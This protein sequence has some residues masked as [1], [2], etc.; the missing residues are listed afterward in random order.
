MDDISRACTTY[1]GVVTAN[2][3]AFGSDLEEKSVSDFDQKLPAPPAN[4]AAFGSDLEEKSV[5]DFDQPQ[6][7]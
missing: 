3:V 6:Q 7:V 2:D 1:K 4:D 5:S